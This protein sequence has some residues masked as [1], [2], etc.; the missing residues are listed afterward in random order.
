[1]KPNATRSDTLFDL[2]PDP[3]TSAWVL[4]HR[5]GGRCK[6]REAGS[7]ATEAQ[8]LALMGTTGHR[9]GDWLLRPVGSDPN[10]K[11]AQAA[12][13]GIEGETAAGV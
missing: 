12:T 10:E 5:K 8:A 1:M 6:W 3:A 13:S 9:G 11:A 2:T 4:W 7:A